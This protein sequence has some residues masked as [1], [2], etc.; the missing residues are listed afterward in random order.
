MLKMRF[1]L[2]C[3]PLWRH[4]REFTSCPVKLRFAPLFLGGDREGRP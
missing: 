3:I 1:R 2:R 4:E